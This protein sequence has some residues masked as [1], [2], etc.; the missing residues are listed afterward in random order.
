[1]ETLN[2]MQEEWTKQQENAAEERRLGQL[3]LALAESGETRGQAGSDSEN[4]TISTHYSRKQI[5]IQQLEKHQQE[6]TQQVKDQ[7]ELI[8]KQVELQKE[9]MEQWRQLAIWQEERD[10]SREAQQEQ[11]ELE[12]EQW[13]LEWECEKQ[14]SAE[15]REKE[16][17]DHQDDIDEWC[18]KEVLDIFKQQ[19][20]TNQLLAQVIMNMQQKS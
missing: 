18:H 10:A 5:T 1:M 4:S 20:M 13:L 11:R 14:W 9:D 15:T 12:K 6:E 8:A 3:L 7:C 16:W 2:I 17:Q 19:S